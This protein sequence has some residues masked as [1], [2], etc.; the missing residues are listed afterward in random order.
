PAGGER[1]KPADVA[2]HVNLCYCGLVPGEG[3]YMT[4]QPHPRPPEGVQVPPIV[5][6]S[7]VGYRPFGPLPPAGGGPDPQQIAVTAAQCGDY[8]AAGPWVRRRGRKKGGRIIDSFTIIDVLDRDSNLTDERLGFVDD[9][10][11]SEFANAGVPRLT[12]D[13]NTL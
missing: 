8:E 4:G 6:L 1:P 11:R 5:S 13:S 7:D 2:E 9:Y 12:T 10:F 3:G